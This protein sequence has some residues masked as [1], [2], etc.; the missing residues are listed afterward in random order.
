MICPL[1]HTAK[2][3]K[4]AH[5]LNPLYV[6]QP[7]L[8]KDKLKSDCC[9]LLAF[10][11]CTRII[12][13]LICGPDSFNSLGGALE[14]LKLFSVQCSG[15][16]SLTDCLNP[17]I[18]F[19]LFCVLILILRSCIRCCCCFSKKKKKVQVVMASQ[20]STQPLLSG[21]NGV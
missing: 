17:W 7:I 3:E 12:S 14:A 11:D 1:E 5:V 15:I 21:S 20:N 4:C 19:F 8:Q 2:Y 16:D 13:S 9:S 6:I 10:R 18:L